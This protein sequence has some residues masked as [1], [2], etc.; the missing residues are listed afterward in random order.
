MWTSESPQNTKYQ[1]RKIFTRNAGKSLALQSLKNNF[2][3]DISTCDLSILQQ[4]GWA[5]QRRN[6]FASSGLYTICKEMIKVKLRKLWQLPLN[7]S[8]WSQGEGKIAKVNK[9]AMYL[10]EKERMPDWTE[11]KKKFF[12]FLALR[13]ASCKGHAAKA[14]DNSLGTG[15]LQGRRAVLFLSNGNPIGKNMKPGSENR[16]GGL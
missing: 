9:S 15:F 8:I 5:K 16:S 3:Y 11:S 4:I 13:S 14:A 12:H 6:N 7:V 1:E 2:Y 10:K